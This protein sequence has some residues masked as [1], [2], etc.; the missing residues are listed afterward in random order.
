MPEKRPFPDGVEN[1]D[2]KRPRSDNGSPAPAAGTNG[3]L[4]TGMDEAARKKA[5]AAERIAAIKA[6][7]AAQAG[8]KQI[9]APASAA[10]AAKSDMAAKIAAMKAKM[11]AKTAGSPSP[12]PASPSASQT[13]SG[14]SGTVQ[15]AQMRARIAEM[16]ARNAQQ[17]PSPGTA[18]P[19]PVREENTV[20]ARG[21]LGVAL[22][23]SLMGDGPSTL[24]KSKAA[25]S[26]QKEPETKRI[27]NPYL[28]QEV[29]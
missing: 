26:K 24:A 8:Q 19:P 15:Q 14:Q 17:R 2:N 12:A 23:P 5:A 1:G 16:K 7:M 3:A 4:T 10:D 21:G 18:P 25:S 6:K 28:P 29:Q 9:P 20:N 13:Q 27:V 11:A 22:H